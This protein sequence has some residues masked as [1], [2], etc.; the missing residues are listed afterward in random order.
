MALLHIHPNNLKA[1]RSIEKLC[2]STPV[3]GL[4]YNHLALPPKSNSGAIGINANETEL[5]SPVCYAANR[6]L[7]DGFKIID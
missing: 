5:T 4:D 6:N 3:P 1:L 7:R 2:Y